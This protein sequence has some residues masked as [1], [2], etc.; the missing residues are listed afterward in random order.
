MI[1]KHILIIISVCFFAGTGFGQLC[2]GPAQG[3]VSSGVIVSAGTFAK[4]ITLTEPQKPVVHNKEVY[5]ET[6]VQMNFG[7]VPSVKQVYTEDASCKEL[8]KRDSASLLI[9]SFDGIPQQNGIPPD[10]YIAVG[11]NHII[12]IVNSVFCI[13]D[14]N[15]GLLKT[16]SGDQFFTPVLSG[17]STF[18]PKILYDHFSKRWVMVW[19]HADQTNKKAYYLLA[20]SSSDNPLGNWSTWALPSNLNGSTLVDQ[21]GDYQGV[22]Y[23]DSCIYITSNQFSNAGSFQYAK[24]RIIPKAQLYNN[25][26]GPVVWNDLW[27]ILLPSY[28][29]SIF[30]VRPSIARDHEDGYYLTFIPNYSANFIAIYKITNPASNPVLTGNA[31]TVNTFYPA[32]NANQLGGGSM[33]LEGGGG[34]LR[35]EPKVMNNKMWFTHTVRN[36]YATSYSAVR[37][38]QFDLSS[39]VPVLRQ[40]QLLG[41]SGFWHFY[42]G[43]DVDKDENIAIT[44][45]RSGNTEYAGAYYTYA[46][47]NDPALRNSC[48]LQAGRA[49]YVK[50]FGSGRNRWG[51]Y[52]GIIIDPSDSLSFWLF[53][54]YV[55]SKDT[56]GTWT[57]QMRL[58]TFPGNN[59][60][61]NSLNFSNIEVNYSSDTLTSYIKNWGS[62]DI[63]ITSI[64]DSVGPFKMLTHLTL[65]YT[66]HPYD[67]AIV[68][69][70]FKPTIAKQYDTV[71]TITTSLPSFAGIAIKGKGYAIKP[72]VKDVLYAST[73]A[74][75]QGELFTVNTNTGNGTLLGSSLQNDIKSL[76]INPKNNVMYGIYAGTVATDVFR[77]NAELG[78][79][80]LLK[81]IPLANAAGICFDTNGVCIMALKNGD[82][83]K[84]DLNTGD[85]LKLSS[86]H[87]NIT[88]ITVN[89]LNNQFWAAY[90]AAIGTNKDKL[91]KVN[92]F[93][94]DTV[95]VGKTGLGVVTN[96]LSFDK[97][98]NLYGVTGTATAVNN[99]IKIDTLT[100][101]GTII[102]ST[103]FKNVTG[104]A[105]IYS[106]PTGVED[107]RTSQVPSD[108]V[109]RQNYPNPF[110]PST[111]IEYSLPASANVKI[112]VYNL[113]GEL[114]STLVNTNVNAGTHR[115]VWDA[116]RFT[117]GTYFYE[118]NA[119]CS[120]GKNYTQ[121]KKMIFMK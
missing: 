92:P 28:G 58:A 1:K 84:V 66:I 98:G 86:S 8:A 109:V 90:S 120:N 88:N 89:L 5:N 20:V 74:G 70:V 39:Q 72:P 53:G 11:P 50:D 12:S 59:V 42:S 7:L 18:D 15:G 91:Y 47:K 65:P 33:L 22:G 96:A 103:S 107:D 41:A 13:W 121:I 118:I 57:G 83:Y 116:S 9:K 108:F 40:D 111:T 81:S 24:I 60:N 87:I 119:N 82:F 4:T 44:Y 10:P 23:D 52:N 100:G 112:T 36:P 79:A 99:L 67:T 32:S 49:N 61:A 106:K 6:P 46:Y 21:W 77:V 104:L 25:T 3:S 55:Y 19:L 93:T 30:C 73:G 48:V 31:L 105:V 17:V 68:K 2:Q 97:L 16:I 56:W 27:N 71:Y 38:L 102:G 80:Y 64:P 114:V 113:L 63:T 35:N 62:N 85:T 14:K 43:M 34:Q 115:V 26:A 54:E 69:I 95:F 94:G 37:Y 45:S 110:N 29:G 76:A 75:N 117:S 51:D 78:D 101:A